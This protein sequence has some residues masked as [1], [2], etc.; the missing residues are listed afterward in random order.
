MTIRQPIVTICGHVDHGKTSILDFFRK[1][2]LQEMEAGGITQKISFTLYP[3]SQIEKAFPLIAKK[4]IELEIPGFLFIDTPGHA[5]FTN[6]RKRG[7]S[8]A[9]LAILVI[10]INEG[11]KPQTAEVISILKHNKTPFIIALN[12][13]DNIS[14]WRTNKDDK[15]GLQK[16][17]E[18]QSI[19]VKP[20]FDERYMVIAGALSSHGFDAD[21]FY[22]IQDFTKKIAMVPCSARTG[23]GMS[24]LMM[25]LCGLSQKYLKEKLKLG[26]EAKGV[27]LE[28]KKD[29]SN[30]YAE[31]VLYDGELE[32]GHEIAVAN[33]EGNP[34]ITKVRVIEEI[35]PLSIRF[36]MKETVHAATGIRMQFSEK[37]DIL[38]G[39]PFL[40]YSGDKEKVKEIFKKE[41]TENI[42]TDKKGIIAKAD[43]LGSLEALLVL[44]RQANIPILKAGIG[45]ISKNDFS[46]AKA[47]LEIDELDAIVLGFNVSVSED[48]KELFTNSG[49]KVLTD[50]VV[51]KLIENLVKFRVEKRNEIEKK[52]LMELATLCK[53]K[54][55]H[56]YVFR[57][58]KPA[59]FGVKVE[60]GKLT[61]TTNFMNT[62]NEDV[63]RIKNIQAD[64][65]SV[66]EAFEGMEVAI[67]IPG[68]NFERE[69]KD[70][71]FLYSNIGEKQF[72]NFKKN[73]ELLTSAELKILQE[74]A[75]IKRK[76]KGN[77]EW[78]K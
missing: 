29:K 36:K 60:A 61:P 9:D 62:E 14:G 33:I 16:N 57:N 8:L 10:D 20:I 22:N 41:L 64:K 43:S 44:L 32:K 53:L 51:Y 35:E 42:K 78:G 15:M 40:A 13:I 21:L 67:S 70:K 12:K 37:M 48:A 56:Q 24:E 31:A 72:R 46:N 30:D 50:E 17:I 58:T 74:I 7:G 27:I 1:T 38:P 6:L 4:G 77:E 65:T 66:K 68:V 49:I 45:N 76:K 54:I 11:I 34:I 25:M 39:M 23:E 3:K 52:K 69:L 55:L 59:I 28:V 26:K 19:N 63:G 71:E 2:S 47:N 18:T 73:K 5:A 75:E